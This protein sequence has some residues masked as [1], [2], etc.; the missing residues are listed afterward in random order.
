[1]LIFCILH[2]L[3]FSAKLIRDEHTQVT[4]D[5]DEFIRLLNQKFILLSPFCGEP[6]CEDNIKAASALDDPAAAAEA[7]IA[8]MGAKTLCIPLE[9]PD[10]ELGS[11]CICPKCDGPPK[12]FALF[13]RSY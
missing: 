2:V 4:H 12:F 6:N 13:G 3:V 7:G 9:Q 11:K 5:W 1:M 8:A 10:A